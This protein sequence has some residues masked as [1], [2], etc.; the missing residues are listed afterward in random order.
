MLNAE[1]SARDVLVGHGLTPLTSIP[2]PSTALPVAWM[3]A[4]PQG[5]VCGFDGDPDNH[6]EPLLNVK[7]LP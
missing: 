4:T 5:S 1:A 2:T 7:T 3:N 6:A